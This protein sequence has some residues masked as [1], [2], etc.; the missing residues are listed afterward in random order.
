MK[1]LYENKNV[2]Y[3]TDGKITPISYV[4]KQRLS[5]RTIRKICSN[6]RTKD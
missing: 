2:D 5:E 4:D 1:K 6:W 3:N